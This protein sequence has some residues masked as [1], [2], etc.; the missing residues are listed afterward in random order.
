MRGWGRLDATSNVRGVSVGVLYT[1]YEVDSTTENEEK[2]KQSPCVTQRLNSQLAASLDCKNA[3]KT[4]NIRLDMSGYVYERT[5][6]RL[7]ERLRLESVSKGLNMRLGVSKRLGIL[8]Q[9]GDL[10]GAFNRL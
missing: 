1:R 4:N 3:Q 7:S 2:T 6:M 9:L 8:K 10:E 5:W